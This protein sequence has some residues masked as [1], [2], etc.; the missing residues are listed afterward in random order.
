MRIKKTLDLTNLHPLLFS[1]EMKQIWLLYDLH[2]MAESR[3][4]GTG[5]MLLNKAEELAK[6]TESEFIT[7][8]TVKDNYVGQKLYKK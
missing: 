1:L 7:L 5:T 2:T 4:Q 6:E 3:C 8:S